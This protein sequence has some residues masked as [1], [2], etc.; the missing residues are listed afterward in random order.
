MIQH[1]KV[2]KRK[3]P[4][5]NLEKLVERYKNLS[6][7]YQCVVLDVLKP[8][9]QEK[10]NSFFNKKIIRKMYH[11]ILQREMNCQGV[12]YTQ[13]YKRLNEKHSGQLNVKT[14]ESFRKNMTINSYLFKDACD[15]L[16]I[17]Y[18]EEKS[19]D[20][21][22]IILQELCFPV[23][24]NTSEIVLNAPD[25]KCL[26]KMK[27]AKKWDDTKIKYV[28]KKISVTTYQ[29]DFLFLQGDILLNYGEWAFKLLDAHEKKIMEQLINALQFLEVEMSEKK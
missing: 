15:I 21:S 4:K 26:T 3:G 28:D 25:K 22:H 17:P 16:N 19:T 6:Y 8:M 18:I 20:K 14:Y 9:M 1:E 10:S 2:G 27:S 11:D 7:P 5:G 12:S 29:S 23:K 24:T 13:L